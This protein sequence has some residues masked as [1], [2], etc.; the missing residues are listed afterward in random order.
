MEKEFSAADIDALS[1]EM[2][3]GL[4]ATTNDQGLPHLTLIASL[5]A[6]TPTQMTFGQFVEGQ[7]KSYIRH[8]PKVGFLVMTLDRN[9]WRG[10]AT[11][12]HTAQ[13]GPE[14]GSQSRAQDA[15]Y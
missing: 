8:N 1:A 10:K 14:F 15:A 3:I 6:I 11:F 4:L 2:K 9:L 13:Q 7:S 5:R 12:T